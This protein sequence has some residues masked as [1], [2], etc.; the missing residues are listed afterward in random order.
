MASDTVNK[1]WGTKVNLVGKIKQIFC[2]YFCKLLLF[3][4]PRNYGKGCV[5]VCACVCLRVLVGFQGSWPTPSALASLLDTLATQACVLK[6]VPRTQGSLRFHHSR[7]P[8]RS[9]RGVLRSSVRGDVTA[10]WMQKQLRVSRNPG[11]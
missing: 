8:L 4:L 1:D 5:R 3:F 6:R 2:H 9:T 7:S 11:S 10:H